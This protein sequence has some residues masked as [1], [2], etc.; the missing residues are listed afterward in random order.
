[1]HAFRTLLTLVAFSLVS[2]SAVPLHRHHRRT[3]RTHSAAS[4][5]PSSVAVS[6]SAA[7]PTEVPTS[8]AE[9]TFSALPT[10]TAEEESTTKKASSTNAPSS[11]HES[12]TTGL[13]KKLF[14]VNALK[15]WTTSTS[16]DNSLP[17]NDNTFGVTKL[18]SALSHDYVTAPD[19]KK[20]V[21]AHYPKGS[22]TFGHSPEGGFSFYATG[23][24]NFNLDNAKEATLSYSVYFEEDFDFNKG[25]KLPGFYGGNS[26]SIA[27]SCSGG[28]RDDRCFSTRFMWRTDGAGEVYTYLP[29]D[30]S[31]NKRLCNVAP[32]S[33]CNDTYGAS[34]GR[35]S[36]YF[37]AGQ[38]KTIGQRVKLN[39]VGQENGELE[40]FVEGK[41]IFTVKGL[42]YRNSDSG[43]IRGI[44]MQTFF[45][46]SNPSWASPKSQNTYFSDFSVAVTETF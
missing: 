11:T 40:L 44:Q 25:G 2:V 24:D 38:R 17:L 42:V 41:S 33:D 26:E 36:F 39:D 27:A 15:K 3:C 9:S 10:S 19:G 35:G 5:L 13:L 45:G 29:P 21:Q 12:T 28:R 16:S 46:G 20:S 30:Y 22:Y 6:Q 31:A 7:L 37:K 8:T 14:P 32:E 43:K 1:M 34:V 4:Q 23:P 18:L